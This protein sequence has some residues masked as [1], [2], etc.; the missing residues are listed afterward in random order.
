MEIRKVSIETF[1]EWPLISNLR[2]ITKFYMR[3]LWIKV[4]VEDGNSHMNSPVSIYKDTA[5]KE[6]SSKNYE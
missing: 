1:S 5:S 6:V 2:G 3:G 4:L